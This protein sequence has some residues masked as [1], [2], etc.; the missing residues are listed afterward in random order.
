MRSLWRFLHFQSLSVAAIA[1]GLRVACDVYSQATGR[2][3]QSFRRHR[4][5]GRNVLRVFRSGDA[6]VF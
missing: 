3:H 5:L 2:Y 6:A 1:V 4:C